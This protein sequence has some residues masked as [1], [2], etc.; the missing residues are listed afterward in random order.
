MLIG[1]LPGMLL[2]MLLGGLLC[3]LLGRLLGWLQFQLNEAELAL[4]NQRF[5]TTIYHQQKNY[6]VFGI[7]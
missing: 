6:E 3:M 2:S 5:I 1:R 7:L 4:S